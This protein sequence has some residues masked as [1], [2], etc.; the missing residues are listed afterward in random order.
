MAPGGAG[1]DIKGQIKLPGKLYELPEN[2][3]LHFPVSIFPGNPEIKPHL[4][5]RAKALG[6]T[7]DK[8]YHPG[9]LA[10][11]GKFRVQ[12]SGRFQAGVFRSQLH[13]ALGI[14]QGL[15]DNEYGSDTCLLGPVEHLLQVVI[16]HL[17][18]EV[19]MSVNKEWLHG[20]WFL[21]YFFDLLLRIQGH[22]ENFS[23]S[24]HF[25]PLTTAEH[26]F[27]SRG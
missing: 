16:K 15:T 7:S 25:F 5:D 13:I 17:A 12:A 27:S 6:P 19:R 10:S 11:I 1:V 2:F 9:R 8:I 21:K 18:A 3:P 22:L 26:Q 20:L 24:P 23:L 14:R 4:A